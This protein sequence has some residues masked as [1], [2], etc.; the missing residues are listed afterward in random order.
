[1]TTAFKEQWN[2]LSPKVRRNLV[3]VGAAGAVFLIVGILSGNPE[4]AKRRGDRQAVIENTLT[5]RNTREV[6]LDSMAAQLRWLTEEQQRKDGEI[7]RLRQEIDKKTGAEA[8]K[9]ENTQLGMQVTEMQRRLRQLEDDTVAARQAVVVEQA[10]VPAA[11]GAGAPDPASSREH[12]PKPPRSLAVGAG[13]F[14]GKP[15]P[16]AVSPPP[17][18]GKAVGDPSLTA[19]AAAPPPTASPEIRV[20]AGTPGTENAKGGDKDAIPPTYIPAASLFS[21][22]LITGMDAPTNV[23]A[24]RQPF[25]TLARIR[26]ETILP[27]NFTADVVD[28]HVLME[29]YG[30]LSSERAYLRGTMISCL[31]TDGSVL[32]ASFPAYAVGE[33]GKVGVRGRLVSKQGAI[34][35]KALVAGTLQGI[36]EAFDTKPV[37]I[38]NTS[39]SGNTSVDVFQGAETLRSAAVGGI[40][41]ALDQLAQFYIQQAQAMYPVIEVDAGREVDLISSGGITVQFRRVTA[42]AAMEKVGEQ[43]GGGQPA[44]GGGLLSALRPQAGGAPAAGAAAG[45]A[46]VGVAPLTV[47]STRRGR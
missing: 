2:R 46:P 5:D 3:I 15:A 13:D 6:T 42:A 27:N 9:Q 44:L 31:A 19:S 24:Q 37:P 18:D 20:I 22:T 29:G 10:K 41:S 7:S 12:A 43:I 17:A 25:P 33:D 11:A 35:A 4:P 47:P 14:Y 1:M 28:C 26:K 39:G 34:L 45:A 8:L 32:E 30:D 38:L 21:A 16:Q 36:S 23:G 40:G